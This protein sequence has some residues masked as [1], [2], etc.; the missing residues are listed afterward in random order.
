MEKR[1][2]AV[3]PTAPAVEPDLPVAD[4]QAAAPAR[5]VVEVKLPRYK[6]SRFAVFALLFG[7]LMYFLILFLPLGG[8]VTQRGGVAVVLWTAW[9]WS[10]GCVPSGWVLA[11]PIFGTAFLPGMK[12]GE[13]LQ[14]L[15]HPGLP[16]LL[17]PALI[18]CMWSRWGLTRRMAL[19]VL[20]KVGTSV[21]AQ[22]VTWLL[23]AASISFITANVVIAIALTPIVL[24]VLKAV[25]YDTPDK[26]LRTTSC[27]LLIIAVGIGSTVGGFLTP[28]AGGQAVIT[29]QALCNALGFNV[30]MGAFAATMALPVFLTLIPVALLFGLVFPVDV[31]RFEGSTD[32]F[33]LQLQKMGPLS[34]AELWGLVIFAFAILLPF[35]EP[36]WRSWIPA[37]FD[38]SPGLIFASVT[39]L[40]ALLPAPDKGAAVKPYPYQTGERLLSLNS[41]RILPLQAFLMWP[42]AMSLAVLV[43]KTGASQLVTQL[44]GNYWELPVYWGTGMFVLLCVILGNIASD[45]AAAGMLAPVIAASTVAAGENP[46]PWLLMMGFSVNFSF[47]VPC[48]CGTIALPI[49]LGGKASWRLPA[50]G[51]V[52]ALCCGLVSWLFWS[53]VRAYDIGFWLHFTQF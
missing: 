18:V 22:A 13:I 38:L 26:L 27:M 39:L 53:T 23:L 47:M 52:C 28:M 37:R 42:T 19:V 34:R 9:Y 16:M 32:Y 1:M 29:W 10:T 49:A 36:F 33:K 46:V 24:E 31:K 17:G 41:V 6:R 45:T 50:Y 8:T 25:G 21:R 7:P 43:D 51:F 44:L 3:P 35:L 14:T 40:L 11:V 48:A 4:T 5:P 12:F 30:S 15:I 2:T 20:G